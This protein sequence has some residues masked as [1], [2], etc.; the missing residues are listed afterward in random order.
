MIPGHTYQ[1]PDCSCGWLYNGDGTTWGEHVMRE[2]RAAELQQVA[3]DFLKEGF[4]SVSRE[5][6]HRATVIRAGEQ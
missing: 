4:K 5:F 3:A 2:A 6:V 1:R